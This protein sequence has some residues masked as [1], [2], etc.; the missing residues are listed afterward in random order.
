MI[1][2]ITIVLLIAEHSCLKTIHNYTTIALDVSI[3]SD[4]VITVVD[5]T[6][7]VSITIMFH[8]VFYSTVSVCMCVCVCVCVCVCAC[9][10]SI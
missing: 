2:E 7:G 3:I 1:I 10:C 5:L 8:E 4:S 6:N 9:V